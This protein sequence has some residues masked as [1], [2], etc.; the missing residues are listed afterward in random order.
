[1][2]ITPG[3]AL[4]FTKDDKLAL[5]SAIYD[6]SSEMEQ[7][8]ED[9]F[10][11]ISEQWEHYDAEPLVER[12]S[13]PYDGASNV[14]IPTV[15]IHADGTV[16]RYM[17]LISA[18][19]DI[20]TGRSD[21]EEFVKAGYPREIT[22]FLNWSARN[23][24]DF[25]TPVTDWVTEIVVVGSSVLHLGW[26]TQTRTLYLRPNTRRTK[27][28]DVEKVVVKRGPFL[29]HIPRERALWDINYP[30][31]ESPIF[32]K[33]GFL[34]W[35]DLV[36]R[37]H[38]DGWD[39]E[40]IEEIK[41]QTIGRG[42]DSRAA[43]IHMEKSERSGIKL[44]EAMILN[45]YDIR[46]A[47]V[48]WPVAQSAIKADGPVEMK[49]DA[50][51]TTV[52]LFFHGPSGRLLKAT[53]KPY[54]LPD[55]PFYDAY[56]KKRPG[57]HTSRGVGRRLRDIQSGQS[58]LVNQA[59]D[60]VHIANSLSG[61][62]TDARLARAKLKLGK[63]QYVSG[64]KDAIIPSTFS[65]II[66]PDLALFNT[67]NVVGE[68]HTGINDPALGRETR[69]GGHPAPATST[70]QLLQQGKQLD[71]I[72]MG[73]IRRAIGRMFL[74]KA[75]LYQQ[76]ETNE[77]GKIERAMGE[78]DSVVIKKWIFPTDTPIQGNL[79]ID[80]AAVDEVMNPQ[81][82]QQKALLT[83]QATAN[84]YA[85]VMQQMQIAANPQLPPAV[86][87][88]G[89]KAIEG[90]SQAFEKILETND[91]DSLEAFTFDI[92][93]LAAGLAAGGGQPSP[94]APGGAGQPAVGG[95]NGSAGGAPAGAGAA[96][97]GSGLV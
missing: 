5:G 63:L 96:I 41:G 84:F 22:R 93:K 17:Q 68:R 18:S 67:L 8:H 10:K 95:G 81:V 69:M 14:V 61:Y 34:G 94:Q 54:G 24:Y 3:Q 78:R 52:C 2:A 30:A 83:F 42:S 77:E 58:A 73:S 36:V 19:S 39:G 46:E 7:A 13:E 82:E 80:L 28:G 16:A 12:R 33:Q 59:I 48:A 55:N 27:R 65:K 9:M 74:D 25:Y 4:T 88:V 23:E 92:G 57:Q 72:A 79:E 53:S 45:S 76:L 43:E 64:G 60:V 6:I 15:A 47:W 86:R 1:M 38:E 29:E 32:I 70:L 31:W 75:T 71:I 40:A 97:S 91:I 66:Q 21:N 50:D 49:S 35:H 20:C 44:D 56:F 51:V 87:S 37:G 26:R 89:L 11:D 90:L 62:T 85:V